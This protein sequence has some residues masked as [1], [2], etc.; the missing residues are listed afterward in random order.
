MAMKLEMLHIVNFR[1]LKDVEIPL[2]D[3][4][5]LIGENNAGKSSVLHALLIVLTGNAP[6]KIDASDYYDQS[7]PIRIEL[8]LGGITA[9]DMDRISDAGHRASLAADITDGKITLV[10][11]VP[12]DGAKSSLRI[13]KLGPANVNLTDDVLGPEMKGK[14]NPELRA[15]VTAL[16]P[17]LDVMLAES[18]TQTAIKEARDR[19]VAALPDG[20]RVLRDKPLGTGIDAA[21]KAFLPE[22]IYIEAVKDV[23]ADVKTT[24]SA[25]F[26]KLL[27]ILLEEV[28]DQFTNIE[29]EFARIQKKLSRVADSSGELRDDRLEQVKKIEATIE[30]FVQESFPGIHLK[31]NIP[32]PELKTIF[33]A[34]EL[35]ADDGHEGSIVSKGDGLKRAVAFAI[36]RAYTVLRDEGLG[37]VPHDDSSR[38]SYLLL[39]EE[40]ELYLYPWAQR[41]LFQALAV[42]ARDHPVLVTTHSPMFFSAESTKI[43]SKFRKV[44]APGQAPHAEVFPVDLRESMSD[45]DAFQI[46]CHENNEIAFFARAVV[47]VEGDSDAIVIARL[48]RLLNPEWDPLQK[49]IAFARIGGKHNISRYRKF[50]SLFGMPVHVLCDLDALLDGFNHLTKDSATVDCHHQ[51]MRAVGGVLAEV[52][53]S[54]IKAGRATALSGRGDARANWLKA[55]AV[56]D[57]GEEDADAWKVLREAMTDFFESHRRDARLAVLCGAGAGIAGAKEELLRALRSEHVYV[58]ARGALEDYYG[59]FDGQGA[60]DKVNH[61]IQFC[62][63]LTNVASYGE[64]LGDDSTVI[65][66]ELAEVFRGIFG[67]SDLVANE[68]GLVVS[69]RPGRRA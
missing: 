34:A 23:A 16:I 20:D 19:I 7:A 17:E 11:V 61:A 28:A 8:K 52:D 5:C 35:T 54:E 47:L 49:N 45:R 48:A 15:D 36:L 50:F 29:T 58:L 44:A 43:F 14:K 53:P 21:I 51:L 67:D 60:A 37:G 40:P 24:D 4:G 33:S 3:F 68:T 46:I 2:S 27:R 9:A 26:G 1:A 42:F 69:S 41:Q 55:K 62:E 12:S 57:G 63:S 31:M 30:G 65:L 56:F 10:R 32:A 64:S 13:S 59:T 25:M 38:P 6:R 22:P 39:F 66:D 18:P